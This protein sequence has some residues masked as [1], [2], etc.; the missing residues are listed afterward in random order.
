MTLI[1]ILL[2]I[3]IVLSVLLY[4][5]YKKLKYK[6]FMY[7]TVSTWNEYNE[8]KVKELEDKIKKS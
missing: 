4:F 6:E 2:C 7:D 8:K 1:V 5:C 3:I